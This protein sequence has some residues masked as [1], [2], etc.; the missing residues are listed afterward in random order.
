MPFVGLE[1]LGGSC[2]RIG[3]RPL[4]TTSPQLFSAALFL[5]IETGRTVTRD[6]LRELLFSSDTQHASRA[7]SLRQLLYRLSSL[8]FPIETVGHLIRVPREKVRS[9]LA[10]MEALSPGTRVQL[11]DAAFAVLPG[12]FP[13]V[14]RPFTEWLES[15]RSALQ[16]AVCGL[17]E[18]D[19]DALHRASEWTLVASAARKVLT[20][21][22]HN[23]AALKALV[24]A[25]LLAQDC[26][27]AVRAIDDFLEECGEGDTHAW[28]EAQRLRRRLV[29]RPRSVSRPPLLGRSDVV[30]NLLEAWQ[31]AEGFESQYVAVTGPP[32]I[33]K[34]RIAEA[35]RDLASSRG[36]RV[37]AHSC[38]DNDFHHPLSL[39]AR[40]SS[41]LLALPGGLGISP[42]A[43]SQVTRLSRAELRSAPSPD[44]AIAVEM[45]RSG[46]HDALLD[47]FDSVSAESRLLVTIDD[48]HR[49]D[50]TSW[51]LLRTLASR[52]R[53]RPTML[54]L[55]MRST[56][57]G[58]FSSY[59]S[60]CRV[61][62]LARLSEEHSRE[63]L[64]GCAP[65]L[66]SRPSEID[67]ALRLARGNP[68]YLQAIGRHARSSSP[69]TLPRDIA[70]LAA[71]SYYSLPTGPRTILECV[72]VLRDFATI[73]RVR[74]M[75][76]VDED[77]LLS[78]LRL[79][80][81]HGILEYNGQR[82]QCSH[83]LLAEALEPLIP[84]TVGVILRQR[85]AVRL[86]E[87]CIDQRFDASLAWAA[88]DAWLAIGNPS[89]AAGLLRRCAAHAAQLGEHSEAARILSRLIDVRL[90]D[91][92]R[93]PIIDDL[94]RFAEIGGERSLRAR[95]L[96]ERLR[97]WESGSDFL[98][99]PS[100]QQAM[101][102]RIA[103]AE[104][105]QNE[106]GDLNATIHESQCALVDDG[107]ESE[108]RLRAGV[109]L[110][111]AADL[112]LDAQLASQ[113][114]SEI[115]LV[116]RRTK[117]SST[118]ALRA[119][120]IYHTV[121]GR[122]QR[123]I[124]SARHIIRLHALPCSDV[125]SVTARR[126]A[127]FALQ[128]L[129]E[130]TVFQS[131][132]TATYAFMTERKVYTESLYLAA[133]LAEQAIARGEFRIA[134]AWLTRACVPL[135]RLRHRSQGVVQGFLSV[136]SFMAMLAGELTAAHRFLVEVRERLRLLTTPR[137][138][139][140]DAAF[141]VRLA[142][143]RHVDIPPEVSI[144]RLRA[145]YELGSRLGRQDSVVEGLWMA[146]ARAGAL[147]DATELLTEYF[148][149]RR[150]ERCRPEWS[151]WHHTQNDPFWQLHRE[152][153][154]RSP[155]VDH[156]PAR[157][158]QELI[159]RVNEVCT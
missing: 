94:I 44:D 36:A 54:L 5:A 149:S 3:D 131:E 11:P 9:P 46:L 57:H 27:A 135:A 93:L 110:L 150:R 34:T 78:S 138:S 92:E 145:D 100:R 146:Y 33:G 23:L 50:P 159:T 12:C 61:L 59:P 130:T 74:D 45:F 109:S 76:A 137:L 115:K 19:L 126:N 35:I 147:S 153:V 68:F 122:P 114:W 63:L 87:D 120:L 69:S 129:R 2:I 105:D 22:P 56:A 72:L 142:V 10:S 82:L 111:I 86:E 85:M 156:I 70:Q 117:S 108:V 26:R 7:H 157:E 84:T 42:D 52:V 127:L 112:T 40:L 47:L 15:T 132:A 30:A 73:S 64:L 16:R 41:Q 20:L 17:L 25:S 106:V 75:A 139:A 28:T 51:A 14:S 104:A 99:R 125:T 124:A 77:A 98:N 101:E 13:E 118:Q 152:L 119:L 60:G 140:L 71:S 37:I 90:P 123:A 43:F 48:A 53:S 151:L 91:S 97:I 148:C 6:E 24:E 55:C 31:L 83:D 141:Q 79:L 1:I 49:L 158:I 144:S 102:L 80:E 143:L 103:I 58:E 96:R 116:L 62:P 38:G 18:S 89:S 134:H 154:P 133:S 67:T 113:A 39:F 29:A 81:E 95:A 107:L 88:A 121:F 65:E 8:G 136:I 155:G 21:D 32:G 128:N 4:L 66:C